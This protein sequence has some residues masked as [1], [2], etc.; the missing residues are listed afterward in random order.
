MCFTQGFE[1]DGEGPGLWWACWLDFC[2]SFLGDAW[3]LSLSLDFKILAGRRL[4]KVF[5]SASHELLQRNH[6][7][8]NNLSSLLLASY[9]YLKPPPLLLSSS[10]P[11]LPLS[12]PPPLPSSLPPAPV[13]IVYNQV[14]FILFCFNNLTCVIK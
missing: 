10:P 1:A 5:P 4:S 11:P 2:L 6:T 12:S 14:Y 7:H 9:S 13:N 3:G 8:A